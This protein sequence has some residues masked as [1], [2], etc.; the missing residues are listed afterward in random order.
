MLLRA[1][2]EVAVADGVLDPSELARLRAVARA[3]GV[4]EAELMRR[5]QD[6]MA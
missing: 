5:I 4:P 1:M 2:I 3:M 6:R